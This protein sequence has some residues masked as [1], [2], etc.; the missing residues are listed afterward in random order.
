MPICDDSQRTGE[1]R[2]ACRES[3]AGNLGISRH[4]EST[5]S[6]ASTPLTPQDIRSIIIG[7]MLAILLGALDSTIISVAL[8]KMAADLHGI[9]LL[10][11]VMSG[12]LI[13]MAVATP[14]YGKL[15]DIYGRRSVLSSAI[16]LFLDRKGTRL[17]SS[18]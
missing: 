6:L 12:Y 18:H 13:A 3:P 17:N 11:W 10:A 1:Y 9:N 7:L 5:V 2:R 8:P 15:G 4:T 14:I 16:V